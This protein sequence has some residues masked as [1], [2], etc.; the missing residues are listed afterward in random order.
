MF[1]QVYFILIKN[2]YFNYTIFRQLCM[3]IILTPRRVA[4]FFERFSSFYTHYT[5]SVPPYQPLSTGSGLILEAGASRTSPGI[6]IGRTAYSRGSHA[7]YLELRQCPAL[8]VRF[9]SRESNP[10]H[11]LKSFGRYT[12]RWSLR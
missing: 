1:L 12:R 9:R 2:I 10:R 8:P 3:Y 4:S 6:N 5:S 11:A 7:L